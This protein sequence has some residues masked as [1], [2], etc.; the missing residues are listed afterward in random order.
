MT[1]EIEPTT[2]GERSLA[3]NKNARRAACED[4]GKHWLRHRSASDNMD[5]CRIVRLNELR[6]AG[7]CINVACGREQLLF[8]TDGNIFCREQLLPFLPPDMSLAAVQGC[9]HIANKMPAPA[10]TVAE[11]TALERQ[12]QDEFVLL[13]LLPSHKRKELQTAHARNLFSDFV[14]KFAAVKLTLDEL[15][16]EEPMAGWSADKLDEFLENAQPVK[17]KIQRAENIRLNAG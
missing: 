15:E 12:F 13:G 10:Q 11:V 16:L 17:E 9:V 8:T 5:T 4:A 14:N 2:H 1:T 3:L 7:A 6:A